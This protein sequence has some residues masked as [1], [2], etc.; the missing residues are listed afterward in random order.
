MSMTGVYQES[1][2]AAWW[3]DVGGQEGDQ[4]LEAVAPGLSSP[5][6]SVPPFPSLPPCQSLPP[7]QSVSPLPPH[8]TIPFP[9]SAPHLTVQA[10]EDEHHE[11][12]GGPQ[13]G[14]G[15]HRDSF[16]VGD[17]SQSRTWRGGKEVTLPVFSSTRTCQRCRPLDPG[18][19]QI[20][21]PDCADGEV[22]ICAYRKVCHCAEGQEYL[23]HRSGSTAC[24][25][26]IVQIFSP[27][28]DSS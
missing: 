3:P 5:Y 12:Q 20:S 16:G 9:L 24:Y 15:H 28:P 10:Q 14:E 22:L 25:F 23:I 4:G 1:G 11:E 7:S 18:P 17:E 6:S 19:T 27:R 21:C 2:R 26:H 8:P 13:W